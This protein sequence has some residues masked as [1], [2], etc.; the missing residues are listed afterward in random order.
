MQAE[1]G[2]VV[3]ASIDG[4]SARP[5]R[6]QLNLAR[7]RQMTEFRTTGSHREP[8]RFCGTAAGDLACALRAGR[9]VRAEKIASSSIAPARLASFCVRLSLG[10]LYVASDELART[11]LHESPSESTLVARVSCRICLA[12]AAPAH[13]LRFSALLLSPYAR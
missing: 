4:E 6:R 1:R 2:N 9:Y 8:R 3:N 10:L 11:N 7:L 5:R 13:G 12:S